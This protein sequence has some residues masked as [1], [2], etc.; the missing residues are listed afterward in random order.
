MVYQSL[1][2][3]VFHRWKCV[4]LTYSPPVNSSV[5]SFSLLGSQP[6]FPDMPVTNVPALR[7][8]SATASPAESGLGAFSTPR[9]KELGT[10]GQA[11]SAVGLSSQSVRDATEAA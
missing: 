3:G 4:G 5:A 7:N 11:F 8:R 6:Y 9:R 1:N 2:G 10:Q